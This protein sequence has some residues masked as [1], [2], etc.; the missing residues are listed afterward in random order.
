V[1]G[2]IRFAMLPVRKI[3]RL[4][5]RRITTPG[6]SYFITFATQQRA[7][8]LITPDTGRIITNTLRELHLNEDIELLAA[9][10]M[11]DHIHFLFTIGTSLK[12][13]QVMGKLKSL[14]CDHDCDPWRW[15]KEGFEH[16]LRDHES[17]EDYAFYIFMNPYRAK[18][19]PLNKSWAWWLCPRPSIFRFLDALTTEPTVPEAW[20]GLSDQ[21][22]NKITAGAD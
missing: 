16:Q 11:P 22:A 9:T 4:R 20:L 1:P 6:A 7:Q 21:K 3:P 14:S 12:V 19:C 10:I 8:V 15:Q 5:F 13:G 17:F 18:L 2:Y